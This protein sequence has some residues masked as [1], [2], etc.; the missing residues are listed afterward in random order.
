[1]KREEVNRDEGNRVLRTSIQQSEKLTMN[2]RK[3]RKAVNKEVI[4][5][6]QK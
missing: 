2:R 4:D 5:A 1:M 3:V 6:A